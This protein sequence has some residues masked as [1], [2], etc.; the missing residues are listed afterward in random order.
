M[1]GKLKL[2]RRN[3]CC[4][5]KYQELFADADVIQILLLSWPRSF[6]CNG[7]GCAVVENTRAD[8]GG[9]KLKGLI[10]FDQDDDGD[11]PELF[12]VLPVVKT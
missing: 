5:S 7:R 4:N 9:Q 2:A 11:R 1:Q 12:C 10:C 3:S 6:D 8:P